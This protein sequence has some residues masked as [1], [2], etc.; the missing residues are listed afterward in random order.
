MRHH[1][2]VDRPHLY[3]E[4]EKERRLLGKNGKKKK[5]KVT[6]KAEVEKEK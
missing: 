4:T 5:Y 1:G 6:K 3:V 2:P